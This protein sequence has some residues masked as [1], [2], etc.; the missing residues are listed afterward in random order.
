M[1]TTDDI[2]ARERKKKGGEEEGMNSLSGEEPQ[3]SLYEV[4]TGMEGQAPSSG[5]VQLLCT[6]SQPLVVQT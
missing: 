3:G 6:M 2:L 5:H 1:R 4:R